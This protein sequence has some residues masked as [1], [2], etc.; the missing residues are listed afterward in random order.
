M[1]RNGEPAVSPAQI[2]HCR[3]NQVRYQPEGGVFT[4]DMG[5]HVDGNRIVMDD[6]RG[7]YEILKLSEQEL[8]LLEA[9][10]D[11]EGNPMAVLSYLQRLDENSEMVQAALAATDLSRGDGGGQRPPPPHSSVPSRPASD[12]R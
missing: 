9:V 3:G 6:Q 2:V 10:K 8:I 5:F 12:E 11:A 1:S 7:S 4:P